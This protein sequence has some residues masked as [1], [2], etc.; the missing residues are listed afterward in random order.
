L[1][2]IL[3]MGPPGAGKGTQASAIA[4]QC[5]VPAISTGAIFRS[6]VRERTPL[7]ETAARFVDAGEYV[8][9]DVTNALVRERLDRPDCWHGFLLDGYP[10]TLSQVTALDDHLA[11]AA[12]AIDAV[13]ALE[14]DT[15]EV[16]R[17][18]VRRAKVEQ[19]TDDTEAVIRRRQQVYAEETAPLLAEY[20]GRG[21]LVT[22]DG[23]GSAQA[24]TGRT[25]EAL[26]VTV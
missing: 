13:L 3:I 15:E 2:R 22:I 20:A 5:G 10:R 18:L 12:V 17:R 1:N 19:R 25:L 26:G 21:L 4:T 14:V 23:T 8:P 9:D 7:G 6:N 16:V 11:D 24:V